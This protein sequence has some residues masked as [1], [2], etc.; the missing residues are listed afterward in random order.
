MNT[1]NRD[2][3][4]G[5]KTMA[6][7]RAYLQQVMTIQSEAVRRLA[8]DEAIAPMDV[9]AM[10]EDVANSFL[11]LSEEIRTF[12]LDNEDPLQSVD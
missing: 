2:F 7:Y 9:A 1:I 6:D 12:A 10:L 5:M 8:E 4:S 3:Q 11:D